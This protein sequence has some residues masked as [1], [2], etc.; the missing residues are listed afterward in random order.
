MNKEK[1]SLEL[2]IRSRLEQFSKSEKLIANYYL[3]NQNN[4]AFLSIHEISEKLSVARSSIVRFA[5]KLGYKGFHSL[6]HDIK[7]QLKSS[8][9]PLEKFRL[10][11]NGSHSDFISIS[12]IAHNEVKNI[13]ALLNNFD[14]KSF[15]KAIG[16][17]SEADVIYTT[18]F[19]LSSFLAG[20][21]S[22]LLQRIGLKSFPTNLGGR[23]L[24]EQLINIDNKDVLIAFSLPPYSPETI[25]A[26]EFAKKQNCKVISFTNS[27]AAPIVSCSDIV[28]IVKSDSTI[29]SNSFSATLVL[30]YALVNEIAL[31]NK[32]RFKETVKKKFSLS[33]T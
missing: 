1:K 23:S 30:L 11:I 26:A 20:I 3:E 8:I 24:D 13:N 16:I 21:T 29:F 17:I 12:E 33:S 7:N 22:Y 10:A 4:I 18:G 15:K 9:A 31:H 27:L 32:T 19:N 14:N 5:K 2:L 6:K 28:F 25:K